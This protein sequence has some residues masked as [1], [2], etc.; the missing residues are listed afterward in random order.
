MLYK[1][2]GYFLIMFFGFCSC[3]T[4][5]APEFIKIANVKIASIKNDTVRVKAAAFFKNR[6][7]VSGQLITDKIRVSFKEK[8]IAKVFAETTEVPAN[9]EFF[10]PLEAVISTSAL[11]QNNKNDVLSG[12]L[13]FVFKKSIVLNFKGKITYRKLFYKKEFFIDANQEIKFIK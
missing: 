11:F 7:S 12:L 6:N 2:I 9:K 13:S 8:E 3:I 10:I 5:R 4:N 1:K